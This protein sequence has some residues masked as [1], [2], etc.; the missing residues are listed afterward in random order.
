MFTFQ[1]LQFETYSFPS[2]KHYFVI[3]T[4]NLV[5]EQLWAI[6]VNFYSIEPVFFSGQFVDE[7]QSDNNPN[8][9]LAKFWL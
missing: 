3:K 5:F 7:T 1:H 4:T 6:L 8:E 9:D 2:R